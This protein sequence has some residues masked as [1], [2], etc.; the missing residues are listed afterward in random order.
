MNESPEEYEVLCRQGRSL[1]RKRSFAKAAEKF[2]GAIEIDERRIEAHEGLGFSFFAQK[3]YEAALVEFKRLSILLPKK[4]SPCLNMGAVYNRLGDFNQAV[5]MLQKGLQ[6]EKD[7][8]EGHY[9]LGIA[10]RGLGNLSMAAASY[11]EAIRLNGKFVDAYQNLA[12]VYMEMEN[13]SQATK[14]YQQALDVKPDFEPAKLGLKA[15]Q[16]SLTEEKAEASPFGRLV[17]PAPQQSHGLAGG[18]RELDDLERNKDRS[19][20][21]TITTNLRRSARDLAAKLR[22][23]LLPS[24]QG[25][26]VQLQQSSHRG[27]SKAMEQY[28][29]S[30]LVSV[31]LRRALKR[32]TLEFRAHEE[33]MNTPDIEF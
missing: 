8:V 21:A 14:Y 12:N 11:R 1:L 30:L 24:L 22:T 3:E 6:R 15:A 23:D 27:L 25:I 13:F 18:V 20:L 31:T 28:Q 9:N 17:A 19:E 26:N 2:R 4:A 33:L 7:S 10:H 5:A 29:Q 32:N 16:S